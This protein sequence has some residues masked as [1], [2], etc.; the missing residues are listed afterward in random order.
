MG[1]S[2]AALLVDSSGNIVGV[3]NDSGTYRLAGIIKVLDSGGSQIDPASEGT[4]QTMDGR[5]TTIDGVLDSIKDTDGIKKITDQLPAGTNEIGK[6]AQGTKAAAG[7]AWPEYIVDSSGNI[8]GVVLDGAVYR[9]QTDAKVAKG[10]SALGHLEALDVSSGVVR[11]K[12]TLY[13]QAG[14]PI[15]F[16]STSASVKNEFAK[17]GGSPSLLVNG[18]TTPVAFTYDADL[19]HDIALQEIRFTLASNSITF[20]NDYF[21][22]TSGPLPN[23]LLVQATTVEGTVTVE[24]IYQNEDFVNFSSPGGFNWVVSSKD[25][26]TSAYLIGGGLVLRANTSDK[27]T[28][29]VR[30]NISSAGIYFRCFIKGNLA[31]D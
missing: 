18:S 13:S 22:A 29:T 12:S 28:V 10:A 7:D 25:L 3:V 15:A 6:V 30:D 2:P 27:I 8:V 26:M 1:L 11:L 16:P 20:G 17:N 31:A 19:D 9:L 23:G 14:D 24:T 21:G 4:L 5:L